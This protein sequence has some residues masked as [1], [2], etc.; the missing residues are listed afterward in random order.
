MTKQDLDNFL[1]DI[2]A[3][4]EHNKL[5]ELSEF[6]KEVLA[7][8]EAIYKHLTLYGVVKSF[9]CYDETVQIAEETGDKIIKCDKQC[10]KCKQ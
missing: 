10:E 5:G 8:K 6:R 3:D 9:Y 1:M 7:S 2:K 4:R